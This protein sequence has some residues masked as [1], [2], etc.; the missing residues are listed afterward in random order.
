MSSVSKDSSISSFS[1]CMPF[2]FFS[3]LIALART[4]STM[5]KINGERQYL[6]LVLDHGGKTLSFSSVSMVLAVGF[7][8][9]LVFLQIFFVK[10]RKFHTIPS[11]LRVFFMSGCCFLSNAFL[12]PLIRSCD[13]SLLV[14]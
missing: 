11:L 1:I 6:C 5:L 14:C 4:S 2:I 8:C 12:H 13:F 9:F 10:L 3:Y 7:F